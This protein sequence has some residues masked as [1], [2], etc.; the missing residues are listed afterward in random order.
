MG[1]KAEYLVGEY[2]GIAHTME[3]GGVSFCHRQEQVG[4]LRVAHKG[5]CLPV[6]RAST[7]LRESRQYS[8]SSRL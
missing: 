8:T 2:I 7:L 4:L 3:S 6:A 1:M 5:P